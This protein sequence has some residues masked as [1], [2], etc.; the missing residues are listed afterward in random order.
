LRGRFTTASEAIELAVQPRVTGRPSQNTGEGLFF[1]VEFIRDNMGCACLHSWDGRLRIRSGQAVAE[2]AA[3]W[4]G[5]WVG[6]R[7]RTDRPVDTE[8]LF[9]RYASPENDYKWLFDDSTVRYG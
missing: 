3:L 1:T 4:P 7:F 9:A 8:R 6:L 5:T 2:Q